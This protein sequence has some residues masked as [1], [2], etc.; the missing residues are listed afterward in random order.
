MHAGINIQKKRIP[1][2]FF[3]D[4]L[5]R[6]EDKHCQVIF[7]GNLDYNWQQTNLTYIECYSFM[8]HFQSGEY[9]II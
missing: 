1:I 7:T 5:Q 8:I 6:K 2:R 4:Y 9:F 3:V